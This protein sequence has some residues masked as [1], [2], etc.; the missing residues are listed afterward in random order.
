MR[1][2]PPLRE[3]LIKACRCASADGLTL[4]CVS[5]RQSNLELLRIVAM[6]M[7][8]AHHFAVHSGLPIWSGSGFNVYFAQVLCMLGK[9]GVDIF[10]LITGY[11]LVAKP[12]K[13]TSLVN[14]LLQ[15]AL[16]GMLIY[17]IFV[18]AGKIPFSFSQLRGFSYPRHYWFIACYIALFVVSPFLG[19]MLQ[20]LTEKQ[21]RWLLGISLVYIS[22]N[23]LPGSD[24]FKGPLLTF[25]VLFMMGGYAWR[26]RVAQGLTWSVPAVLVLGAFFFLLCY[27]G[28]VDFIKQPGRFFSYSDINKVPTLALSSGLFLIFAKLPIPNNRWINRVAACTLGV[29]LIHDNVF[30]RPWL[31]H[32]AIHVAKHVQFS[33]FIPWSIAIIL[34]VYI[35][36]T[37]LEWGRQRV[38]APLLR[39]I[40]SP[41]KPLDEQIGGLFDARDSR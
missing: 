17:L 3:R 9:V 23:Y 22:S 39:R 32:E 20:S 25:I 18:I 10:V 5:A 11:F 15:T 26:F 12:C 30:V 16:Y 31:W 33:N 14:L 13:A 29:Y 24:Y 7:I 21:Y 4:P 34:L 40:L 28:Y 36:C 19:K 38:M 1:N 6:L 27:V 41:L 35:F 37:L 8:V 2:P